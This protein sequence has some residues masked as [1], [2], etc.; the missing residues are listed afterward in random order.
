MRKR[1][2][3]LAKSTRQKEVHAALAASEEAVET[4]RTSPAGEALGNAM[5]A[6]CEAKAHPLDDSVLAGAAR[7]LA[8]LGERGV[9]LGAYDAS[10]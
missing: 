6:A 7:L 10:A 8:D 1:N 5:V 9:L 2:S 4:A 3:A